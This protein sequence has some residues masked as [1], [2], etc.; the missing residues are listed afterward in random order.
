[1]F[2][3]FATQI[4]QPWKTLKEQRNSIQFKYLFVKLWKITYAVANNIEKIRPEI[5]KKIWARSSSQTDTDD[6]KHG[7]H[8]HK[9]VEE[10]S[11][12]TSCS[13]VYISQEH[14]EK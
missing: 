3:K 9:I 10:I 5:V 12:I 6:D 4:A 2:R 8:R 11:L 1:L 7:P 13:K 14:I